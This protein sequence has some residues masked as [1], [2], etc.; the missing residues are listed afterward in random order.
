MVI[1]IQKGFKD[2][3][4]LQGFVMALANMFGLSLLV[5]FLSHGLIEVPRSLWYLADR[6]R[7]LRYCEFKVSVCVD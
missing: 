2:P 4:A 3:K 5:I 1:A 6:K 7:T